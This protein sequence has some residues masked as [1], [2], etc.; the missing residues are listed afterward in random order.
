MQVAPKQLVD[1]HKFQ[2]KG[3]PQMS[4][5]ESV[6]AVLGTNRTPGSRKL[7]FANLTAAKQIETLLKAR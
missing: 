6:L 7:K 1:V 5:V 4:H 2:T 3:H